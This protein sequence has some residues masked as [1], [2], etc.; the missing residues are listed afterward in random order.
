MP[1]K[2]KSGKKSKA[3]PPPKIT[4]SVVIAS[5]SGICRGPLFEGY[6]RYLCKLWG[7]D[8]AVTILSCSLSNS[9]LGELPHLEA[10]ECARKHG[11]NISSNRAR[12][13][14]KEDFKYALVIAMDR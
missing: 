4:T 12:L 14:L 7:I 1:T 9:N 5:S 10:Q 3:P 2:K 8:N 6:L 13:I 11:L